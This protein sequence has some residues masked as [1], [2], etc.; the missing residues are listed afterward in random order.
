M[1][2]VKLIYYVKTDAVRYKWEMGLS[3]DA[4]LKKLSKTT[5]CIS[6]YYTWPP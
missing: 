6:V 4:S 1:L 3:I 2:P 5:E